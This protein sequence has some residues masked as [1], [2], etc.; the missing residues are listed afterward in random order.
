MKRIDGK[1]KYFKI[2]PDIDIDEL[3]AGN[4]DPEDAIL[5]EKA[6]SIIGKYKDI[7]VTLKKGKFGLYVVYGDKNVSLKGLKKDEN[8]IKI[9]DVIPYIDKKESDS[10]LH[11]EIFKGIVRKINE[12]ASIRNGKFGHYIFYK[13]PT[14]KKPKFISLKKEKIDYINCD[15]SELEEY[16]EEKF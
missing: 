12:Y 1:I 7:D 2:K 3:K 16:I 5:I 14:M 15:I 4:I 6:N 8:E 11:S 13:T 10:H 9:D